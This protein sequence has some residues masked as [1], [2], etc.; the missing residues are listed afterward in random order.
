[1]VLVRCRRLQDLLVPIRPIVISPR[2]LELFPG[3]KFCL[4]KP[5][6]KAEQ[7]WGGKEPTALMDFS[8]GMGYEHATRKGPG[9]ATLIPAPLLHHWC[10]LWSYA[11]HDVE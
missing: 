8:T 4:V 5:H 10:T 2:V 3:W 9:D 1:V 7:V 6:R 11:I